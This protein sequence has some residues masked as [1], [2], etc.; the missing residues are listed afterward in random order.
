MAAYR[1]DQGQLPWLFFLEEQTRH[2]AEVP[3]VWLRASA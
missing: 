1:R 3:S 2:E